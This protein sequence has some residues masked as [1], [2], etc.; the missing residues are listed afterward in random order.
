[1]KPE[2][3]QLM[4]FLLKEVMVPLERQVF[5]LTGGQ[6]WRFVGV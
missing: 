3:I 4:L 2:D 5:S 1:M 6:N